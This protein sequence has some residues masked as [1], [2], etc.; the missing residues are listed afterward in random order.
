MS[1]PNFWPGTSIV[2]SAGNAF[3]LSK[4]EHSIFFDPK[5]PPPPKQKQKPGASEGLRAQSA[6]GLSKRARDQLQDAPNAITIG[7]RAA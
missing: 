7:K 6:T 3:D 5:R 4:R 2:K 1:K